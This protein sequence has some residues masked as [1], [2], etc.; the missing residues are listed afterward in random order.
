MLLCL[1]LFGSPLRIIL[2]PIDQVFS[3]IYHSVIVEIHQVELMVVAI[4]TS[5]LLSIN[6]FIVVRI[7]L[8][9]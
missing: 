6:Q 8:R 2:E 7:C 4:L 3:L 1:L 5:K 9:E